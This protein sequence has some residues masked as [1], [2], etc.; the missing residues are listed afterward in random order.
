MKKLLLAALSVLA[1]STGY[2]E[3]LTKETFTYYEV[4]VGPAPLPMAGVGLGIRHKFNKEY[5]I[6]A[7]LSVRTM[8]I[9]SSVE[10][11]ANVLK[12]FNK[13]KVN[14]YY[15]GAGLSYDQ[16]YG[17]C[18]GEGFVVTGF[19]PHFVFGK[20]TVSS[21]NKLSFMQVEANIFQKVNGAG[22]DHVSLLPGVSFRVG[23]SF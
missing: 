3:E 13:N 2:A 20:E 11:K 10:A 8:A 23:K 19:G 12:Y 7:S 4:V 21:D 18:D 5:A 22:F 17:S 16:V 15:A 1:V 9:I 6:D 14:N